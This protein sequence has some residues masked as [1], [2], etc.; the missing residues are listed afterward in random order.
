ML[1]RVT[2]EH[3]LRLEAPED[4]KRFKLLVEGDIAGEALARALGEAGRLEGEHA[5]IAPDWLRRASGLAAD[6]EWQ[7]GFA[8]MVE[9][10]AKQGWVNEA[11]AIRAHIERDPA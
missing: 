6:P 2:R 8:K 3:A 9:F 5:W 7:A 11:G 1:I 10:A 4:L